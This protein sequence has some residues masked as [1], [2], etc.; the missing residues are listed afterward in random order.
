MPQSGVFKNSEVFQTLQ[1]E[2][3]KTKEDIE[4]EQKRW[5]TFLQKPNRPIPQPKVKDEVKKSTYKPPI[6]KQPKPL[7]D[8]EIQEKLRSVSPSPFCVSPVHIPL[9]RATASPEPKY[10][11]EKPRDQAEDNENQEEQSEIAESDGNVTDTCS[12]AEGECNEP[13]PVSQDETT[14]EP[15]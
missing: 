4:A 15:G 2:K 7:V 3:R 13:Q 14:T 1:E 11:D 6:I 5:T 9:A 10:P 12:A 8:P